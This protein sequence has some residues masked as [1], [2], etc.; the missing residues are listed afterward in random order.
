MQ[1]HIQRQPR[2]IDT[3]NS[4]YHT[5]VYPKKKSKKTTLLSTCYTIQRCI[6][7]KQFSDAEHACVG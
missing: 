3:W 5:A 4:L 2:A 1:T 6:H 7:F